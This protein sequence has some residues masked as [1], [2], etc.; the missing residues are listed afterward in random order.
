MK[1]RSIILGTCMCLMLSLAGCGKKEAD[2]STGGVKV[3]LGQYK[4]IEVNLA[5]TEVTDEEV[6]A[7]LDNF[8][9][10]NGIPVKITDRTDVRDGDVANID[11]VGKI[12]GVA[13]EGGT[14]KD[15]NLKIGSGQFIDGFEDGLIGTNVGETVDVKA[16]FPK[17]Y[18]DTEV[19]G[20]EAI[21]TVTVNYIHTGEMEPLTDEVIV[22]GTKEKYKTIDEYKE[23]IRTSI[24]SQKETSANTQ[25]EIDILNT[26][27]DN[28]TI[29]GIEQSEYDAQEELMRKYYT[30]I[31]TGYGVD[32]QTYVYVVFN[33][34]TLDQF[35]TELKT[36]AVFNINQKYLLE[37]IIKEEEI[38]ISDEE[39]NTLVAEY[40]LDTGY[41]T[42]E[43]F[44]AACN[45][46]DEVRK[47][48]TMEKAI[49]LIIDS[50]VV[51]EAAE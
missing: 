2:D 10:T 19:A 28:A 21:F 17:D 14:D 5:S 29:T 16:T 24:K 13:F 39:Y 15:S 47:S 30:D 3:T 20:K 38:T 36:A 6:Q 35:N 51:K 18:R 22:A 11:Y 23:Y 34:M 37:E 31:A 8:N 33:G 50:A 44:E 12:D 9:R 46:K 7:Q 49:D 48:L 43:E 42:V 32:F 25:K 27:I 26:A 41:K 40:M 45:G 1:K 4:G